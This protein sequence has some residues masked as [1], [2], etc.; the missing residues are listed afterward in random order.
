MYGEQGVRIPRVSRDQ[1]K[2]LKQAGALV[3]GAAEQEGLRRGDLV[4][5]NK[6]GQG[7]ITHVGMFVGEGKFAHA[8]CSKGVVISDLAKRYYQRLFVDSG[9]VCAVAE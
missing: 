5:F 4:F 3:G 9:S 6:N 1:H 8:C 2:H 7:R